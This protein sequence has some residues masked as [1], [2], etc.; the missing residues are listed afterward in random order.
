[1]TRGGTS[2]MLAGHL[3]HEPGWQPSSP[4]SANVIDQ[5][6]NNDVVPETRFSPSFPWRIPNIS[7][8]TPTDPMEG[9]FSSVI[10]NSSDVASTLIGV[11]VA[12]SWESE[13]YPMIGL[14]PSTA[15]WCSSPLPNIVM[16]PFSRALKLTLTGS[17]SPSTS[18]KSTNTTF[19][20]LLQIVVMVSSGL[21][22][23]TGLPTKRESLEVTL[24][25]SSS[26]SMVVVRSLNERMMYPPS[27]SQEKECRSARYG[28]SPSTSFA[29]PSGP[30]LFIKSK[31][32][33]SVKNSTSMLSPL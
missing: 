25:I 29:M 31:L 13:K 21:T 4:A 18:G 3:S 15:P 32:P 6:L 14:I 26:K 20:P 10:F 22:I 17:T 11:V 23:N 2:P 16:K 28:V 24:S 33:R 19:P 5:M 8:V 30:L 12:P 1:M 27:A 9:K 7:F